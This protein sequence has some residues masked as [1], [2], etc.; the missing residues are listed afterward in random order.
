MTLLY[1]DIE[2]H[3]IILELWGG[4]TKHPDS[5]FHFKDFKLSPFAN[6]DSQIFQWVLEC[7]SI[8]NFPFHAR[9]LAE[10]ALECDDAYI[11][12][13]DMMSKQAA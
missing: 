13:C 1:S 8:L 9:E 2:T 5:R 6:T 11:K 12:Y 4:S 7:A 10:F 3:N